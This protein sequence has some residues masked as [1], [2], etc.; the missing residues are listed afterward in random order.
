MDKDHSRKKV[1]VII[2]CMQSSPWPA[3]SQQPYSLVAVKHGA[4]NH[5]VPH[6]CCAELSGILTMTFS[7]YSLFLTQ[8]NSIALNK[9]E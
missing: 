2:L 3:I 4:N 7:H 5:L 1:L 6:G 9:I 8:R